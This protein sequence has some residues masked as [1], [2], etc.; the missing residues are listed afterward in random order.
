MAFGFN[1]DN[2][3]LFKMLLS[4]NNSLSGFA[5]TSFGN[6]QSQ[7]NMNMANQNLAANSN[8][9]S[10]TNGT[11]TNP[12]KDINPVKAGIG[13][14][15]GIVNIA[16]AAMKPNFDYGQDNYTAQQAG[17]YQGDKAA[18]IAKAA[19]S[20]IPVVGGLLGGVFG[21]IAQKIA[22]NRG[23]QKANFILGSRKTHQ[24][25]L[26]DFQM[27]KIQDNNFLKSS[28]LYKN[29]FNNQNQQI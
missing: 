20:A 7:N 18:G 2:E 17:Q 9:N 14:A 8:T 12:F 6:N 16:Q 29:M 23:E 4:R 24:N 27:K 3:N 10:I 22:Q 11:S 5:N 21:M 28:D 19:G 26:E 13:A 25:N 1:S 15:E